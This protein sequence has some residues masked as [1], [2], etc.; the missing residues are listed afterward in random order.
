MRRFLERFVSKKMPVVTV[1]S[2]LP[3]S[4]TS[5]LMKMVESGGIPPLRDNIREPDEDNPNGYY[6][7]ERVKQLP[8]G[9]TDWL[10]HAEGKVVKVVSALLPYLPDSRR[11]R[12]V[13]MERDMQEILASQRKMLTRKGESSGDV[14]DAELSK[15]FASHLGEID[16]WFDKNQNHVSILKINYNRLIKDN[17]SD[18]EAISEFLGGGLDTEAMASVIDTSLYR[19]RG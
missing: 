11:Y 10:S 5:L 8:D 13:F 3:R 19:N 16:E 15:L 12:I 9:D 6:E 1:V 7:Y 4:G 14:D 18:I 2:G 17:T